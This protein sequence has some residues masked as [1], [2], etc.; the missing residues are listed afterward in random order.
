M[1][2]LEPTINVLKSIAEQRHVPLPAVA[3]N[4]SINKGRPATL[5]TD[6]FNLFHFIFRQPPS[7]G[8][9]ILFRL[10]SIA[11]QRHVPLPAVALNYSINKGVLPL[12]GVRD[13]GQALIILRYYLPMLHKG[14]P[15]TLQTD[16]FNLFHF[17]F[18]QPTINVLKSIAEQRHVPLPAVALN[19]SIN[20]GVLPLV[21]L[22]RRLCCG[23]LRR[24]YLPERRPSASEANP[25]KQILRFLQRR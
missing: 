5:Q 15:A 17:I 11:E 20:K 3:L 23:Q 9:H 13:A 6:S 7:K 1:H 4:Y 8:L 2:L 21:L 18:R 25:W 22:K 19:Y 14:R 24:E 16:S 10:A 12:V